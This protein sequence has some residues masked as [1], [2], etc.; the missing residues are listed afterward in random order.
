VSV[1]CARTVEPPQLAPGRGL[2][3]V[4][5]GV[6]LDTAPVRFL[7]MRLTANMTVVRLGDG[8]L[9]L[10]SPVG[11]TPERRA[12]VEALGPVAHLYAPNTFHHLR[13]GEW[14]AAFPTACLHAPKGLTK[15]RPDLRIDR[16]HGTTALVDG[17]DEVPIDG[18]RLEEAVL[19]HR[20]SRTLIVAD[21]VHNIGRPEHAWTRVYTTLAGFYG[22]VALSR[23]IRW[24]GFRDRRAA[25]KSVERALA[26]PF[27]RVVVGHGEPLVEGARASFTAALGWLVPAA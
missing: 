3:R 16:L 17:L 8:S 19:F 24:T 21:L 23:V 5:D 20:P 26:L 13:I 25:R 2:M 11:C 7:G 14:Q 27:E 15:K 22:R 18:F 6:W 4:A 10:H 9:L 1:S 12:A